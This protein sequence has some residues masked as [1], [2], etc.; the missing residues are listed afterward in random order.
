M[1]CVVYARKRDRTEEMKKL[2]RGGGSGHG[3]NK[4]NIGRT[5]IDAVVHVAVNE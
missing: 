3:G 1:K 5:R 2:E 4:D